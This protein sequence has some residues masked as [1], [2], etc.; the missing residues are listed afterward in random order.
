MEVKGFCVSSSVFILWKE[1]CCFDPLFFWGGEALRLWNGG[2][3]DEAVVFS[4]LVSRDLRILDDI[5]GLV[6]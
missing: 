4:V 1:S 3:L 6:A 5:G 2:T